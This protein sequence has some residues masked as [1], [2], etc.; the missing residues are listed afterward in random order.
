MITSMTGFGR[1][2]AHRDGRKITVEI[3]SVNHRFLDMNIKM[4]RRYNRFDSEIRKTLKNYMVRGK[5][6]VSIQVVDEA[7]AAEGLKFNKPLA[8]AYLHYL[9]QMEDELGVTNDITASRLASFP[10][11]FMHD[12]PEEDEEELLAQI[13]EAVS[14]AGESFKAERIREGEALK[15]DLLEKLEELRA[16][17]QLVKERYPQ[18]IEEYKNRL[19][20]KLAEV[21]ADTTIDDSRLAAELVIYSDKLC[22]DEETVRLENHIDAVKKTLEGDGEVGRRLDFLAQEMNREAN[23]ILSKANDLRT[24]EIGVELKTCIEK[25]REQIQNLE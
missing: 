20:E 1:C 9:N 10:D 14:G 4:P 21:K 19:L 3:K 24:S 8:E 23:T 11:I 2:E 18:I 16:N 5:V 17:V 25:I 13:K 12:E 7:L 6:D 22:T 15:K